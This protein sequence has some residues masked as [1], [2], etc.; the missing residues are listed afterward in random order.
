M[1]YDYDYVLEV[2]VVFEELCRE[3]TMWLLP[4][5][6]YSIKVKVGCLGEANLAGGVRAMWK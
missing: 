3:E 1:Y 4:A 2:R 6:A 5:N